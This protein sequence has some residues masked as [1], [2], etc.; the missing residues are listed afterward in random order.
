MQA[1]KNLKKIKKIK[2]YQ[3]GTSEQFGKNPEIPLNEKSSFY[4]ASPYAS[5]KLFGYWITKNYRESY[6]IFA[7]NGLLFN[8]ESP[9]RGETF[10]TKKIIK[11]FCEYILGNTNKKL[12]MGNL[13]SKRDWGHARD[14]VMAMWKML[15]LSKPHDLVISTGKQYSVKDFINLTAKKL[16]IPIK[17]KGKGL[18]EKAFVNNKIIIECKK[19]YFRPNEVPSLLGDFN[20]AKKIIKWKPKINIHQ[21]IDEMI[22]YELKNENW[23]K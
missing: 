16:K 9:V 19:K 23:Q 17:W 12:Y 7:V 13:Y 18:Y 4:P 6:G 2:F 8:H 10:V 20:K 1:I 5:S 14:Y 11:F 21:L 3:A 22:S 15:Q